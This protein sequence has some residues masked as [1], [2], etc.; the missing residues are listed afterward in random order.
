MKIREIFRSPVDRRIEEVIKVD[1]TDEDTVAY[2]LQEYVVTDHIRQ[3]FQ[4]VLDAYQETVH[5]PSEECSVWVSGF[6]GSGKSSFAKVLGYLLENPMIKGRKAADHI[7]ERVA[8]DR[9]RA[10]V[11]TIHTQAPTL[12]VF[13]DLSTSRHL[14]REGE[15]VALPLYRALLER[16][17]YS[18]D[19]ALA[20]LEF[21]LEADG[22][23]EDFE[24]EVDLIV[25][26]AGAWK[27]R[28]KTALAR[29]EASQAMHRLRPETYPS[30]DSLARALREPEID[31]DFIADR[32]PELMRRRAAHARRLLFVVDEVG[33]YVAR[34]VMRMFDLIGFA[35]A[36]QKKRSQLWLVVTSQEKLQDVVES[37]EGTRIELARARDRFPITVDL[38]PSDIEE[39]VSRRLLDKNAEGAEAVRKLFRGHRNQL[40]ENIRLDS[41]ARQRDYP[42]EAYVRLYPL[43]PYQVE[44][45]I[46]AVSA[47]RARGGTGP[48]FGGSN[49]TLIKLTQQLL[50]HQRSNLAE[51]DVGALATIDLAYNLL[52]SIIPTSWQDEINRV[53]GRHGV[54]A[55]PTKVAKALALLTGVR[56][57][58]LTTENLA[59]LL[60]ASM[61]SE[62][63]RP[64]VREAL[65]LLAREETV[66]Q[67]D[68]GYKLQSP[69]E[70]SWER[71]RR[72]IDL[73]P[74]IGYQLYRRALADLLG[75]VTVEERRVFRVQVRVGETPLSDGDV[76][77]ALE[78]LDRAGFELA[79]ERSREKEN[80]LFW[81]FEL[82]NETRNA[83][84]ELHRS[85]EMIRRHQDAARSREESALLNE[86]HKRRDGHE[87]LLRQCL[88]VDLLRGEMFFRGSGEEPRGSDAKSA[89]RT[90]LGAKIPQIYR[91]L[92]QFAASAKRTDPVALLQSDPLEGLPAY[93]FDLGVLKIPWSRC[94]R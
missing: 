45:F 28:R 26:K 4:K 27:E 29:N 53:A 70:K 80:W 56:G 58:S 49:R 14:L 48:Q 39:V 20:Q 50:V 52:D 55:L 10:L 2:E 7:F 71:E 40:L 76:V 6:F 66:R 31:A 35:H 36:V 32:A 19:F 1:L 57:L 38:V 68:G 33:Q 75:G 74:S 30:P 67:A 41:P 86:E 92:A 79:R 46:D 94:S 85:E 82:S 11:A 16:L 5:R 44:L 61:D 42:E 18:R 9:L 47:H 83:A 60:H 89:L 24:A 72:G 25:G 51:R 59:A 91:R 77:V 81:A 12:T 3:E 37:L 13:V 8:D 34:D 69:E 23:L 63:L 78:E 43:L 54:D 73:K 21:D 88:E 15:S 90:A 93:L 22:L 87:K 65:Q 84:V 62:T 17:D 64:H